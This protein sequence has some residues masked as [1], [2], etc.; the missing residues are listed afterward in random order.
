MCALNK[1][2]AIIKKKCN[3]QKK[4]KYH[5]GLNALQKTPCCSK[6]VL[7][8]SRYL[9]GLDPR[10]SEAESSIVLAFRPDCTLMWLLQECRFSVIFF[11]KI[12]PPFQRN[13]FSYVLDLVAVGSGWLV[14]WLDQWM[15]GWVGE[16][17]IVLCRTEATWL[18][19]LMTGNKDGRRT[20][21]ALCKMELR[22]ETFNLFLWL[23]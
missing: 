19:F 12:C 9:S 6:R 23:Q 10:G 3:Y 15:G 2:I 11:H 14:D 22:V 7:K 18:I 5:D 20:T 8:G 21:A 16:L 13:V 17:T 1:K 4:E